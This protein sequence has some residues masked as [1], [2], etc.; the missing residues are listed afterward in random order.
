MADKRG[1]T[2]NLLAISPPSDQAVAAPSGAPRRSGERIA[3]V[4]N[5]CREHKREILKM[6]DRESGNNLSFM[7]SHCFA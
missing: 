5:E 6:A 3:R 4:I 7:V 2:S 1:E